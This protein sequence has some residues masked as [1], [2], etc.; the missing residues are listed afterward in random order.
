MVDQLDFLIT[1]LPHLLI[2]FPGQRPGGLL[3]SV[4]LAIVAIAAGFFIGLLVGNGSRSKRRSIRFL[5]QRYVDIFRGIPLILLV[6]LIHQVVGIKRFG[7]DFSPLTAALISL[8][9]YSGAYQAE[10]LRAGL[11]S[12][13]SSQVESAQ[14]LGGSRWSNYW[15]IKLPYA[16]Q[17]MLPAFTGQA[18][19]LFKDTSVVTVISV[20]ELMTTARTVLGSDVSNAPY[21]VSLYLTVGFLYFCVA[22]SFSQIAQRRERRTRS[23]DL[24]HSLA[25]Y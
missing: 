18:I 7:L 8:A 4:L 14:L 6:I 20:A 3:L 5:S 11:E 25:N 23:G 17:V 13:P 10:I 2:G 19:S 22:F 1:H 15:A 16:F 21:W 9:L 24:V 12:V